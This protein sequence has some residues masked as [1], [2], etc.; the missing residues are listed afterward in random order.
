ME[1]RQLDEA[2]RLAE[3]ALDAARKM[4]SRPLIQRALLAAQQ[5]KALQTSGNR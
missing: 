1:A 2:E 5:I 3:V 4:N